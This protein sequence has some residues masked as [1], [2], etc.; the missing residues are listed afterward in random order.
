MKLALSILRMY[1][2]WISPMF[3]PACRYQ[4]TCSDYAAEAIA[5]HGVLYGAA[6]AAWRLVRCHPFAKGGLDLVPMNNRC[7][8]PA[9]IPGQHD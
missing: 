9:L 5:R 2:R 6:L 3:L 7:S 1:Q 8:H 4:P